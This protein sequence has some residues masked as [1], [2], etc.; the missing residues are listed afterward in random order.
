MGVAKSRRFGW[1]IR[2]RRRQLN[3]TQEQLARRIKTSIPYIG[4]MEAGKRHPS[5]QVIVRVA[6]AL[7]LDAR[8]LFLLAN[9][10]VSSLISEQPES[11]VP[12]A[13]NVFVKD[14]NLRETPQHHGPRD[15]DPLAGSE[16]GRGTNPPRLHLYP[17]HHSSGFR[18]I[19]AST[20]FGSRGTV[21]ALGSAS[22]DRGTRVISKEVPRRL[23]Y[24]L[25]GSIFAISVGRGATMACLSATI[26]PYS[27]SA[28]WQ[29]TTALA[30]WIRFPCEPRV[31]RL[32]TYRCG[33]QT[34]LKSRKSK[35][36]QVTKLRFI[37][38]QDT[39]L[40]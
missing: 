4:Q 19:A 32:D 13:W 11:D 27:I 22:M 33:F 34:R 15:G 3:L 2:E 37:N 23:L 10:K 20:D 38:A 1:V 36:A 24:S 6:D 18:P 30:W 17:E 9:P 5:G 35:L 21:E 12:S 14:V 26:L 28:P 29:V 25:E 16:D 40:S 31:S 39:I 7:G 8:D